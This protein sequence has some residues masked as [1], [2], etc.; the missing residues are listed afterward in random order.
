MLNSIYFH[1]VPL[2]AGLCHVSRSCTFPR[3]SIHKI[4]LNPPRTPSPHIRYISLYVFFFTFVCC[5]LDIFSKTINWVVACLLPMPTTVPVKASRRLTF[6]KSQEMSWNWAF[7]V[8]RGSDGHCGRSWASGNWPELILWY[9]VAQV[10]ASSSH[11]DGLCPCH[12]PVCPRMV[13]RLNRLLHSR[14]RLA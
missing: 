10:C 2:H 14:T 7:V 3:S 4:S 9:I 6:F 12:V 8:V 13:P 11:H 5:M 1:Y